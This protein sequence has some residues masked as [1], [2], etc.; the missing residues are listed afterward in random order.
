VLI[1]V[2]SPAAAQPAS[3]KAAALAALAFGHAEGKLAALARHRILAAPTTKKDADAVLDALDHTA[4]DA[5]EAFLV[6]QRYGSPF[7]SAAADIGIGDS[8]DCQASAIAGIPPPPQ[9][10]RGLPP[11]VLAQY[12]DLMEGLVHPLRDE[13]ARAWERAA[14][15]SSPYWAARA[16]ER[17][18]GGPVPGC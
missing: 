13:A 7:W 14:A 16:R 6:V 1:V 15:G 8:F 3:W 4:Q 2:A 11:K 10:A 17:L 18:A 9:V 5:R 12:L